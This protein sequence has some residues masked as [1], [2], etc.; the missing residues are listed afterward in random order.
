MQCNLRLGSKVRTSAWHLKEVVCA[1]AQCTYKKEEVN[2][3][4]LRGRPN[5]IFCFFRGI[6]SHV[7]PRYPAE[8]L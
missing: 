3:Y 4:F 1:R 2:T 6:L 7:N 5:F 8:G